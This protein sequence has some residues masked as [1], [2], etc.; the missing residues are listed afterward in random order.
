MD[1]VASALYDGALVVA[2]WTT[3]LGLG[4]SSD[5]AGFLAPLR[6][7][8][9]LANLIVLDVVAIPLLVWALTHLFAVPRDSAIGLLLVGIC[10]AGPLGI[11]AS[12]IA[13]GDARAAASFVVVLE[14]ANA[15]AI[16]AWVAWLLP[17]GL[18]VPFGQLIAALAVFVLAPLGVGVGLRAWRGHGVERWSAPLATLSNLLVLLVIILV[19]IRYGS[20]VVEAVTNGVAPVA[21]ITVIAALALGWTV[22]GPSA[23]LRVVVALVTGIRANGLALA[24]A[25]ASF[26]ARPAV[27][28]AVV[29]FGAFSVVL[30]MATAF[31]VGGRHKRPGSGTTT[32]EPGAAAASQ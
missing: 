13:G 15:V 19:V 5:I 30:P 3:G 26:P 6:N 21:A 17:P 2:L 1:R 9:L 14:T 8:K 12:R 23:E 11:T 4:L 16:P 20:D 28:A 22:A 24:M 27:H 29:T 18:L 31:L 32:T 25:Q 7:T 10:S